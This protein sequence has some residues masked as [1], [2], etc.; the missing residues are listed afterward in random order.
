MRKTDFNIFSQLTKE[1]D[2]FNNKKIHIAGEL[3]DDSAR[4]LE[5]PTRG[6][7]FSQKEMLDLIDLYYN[8]KFETGH[9]DTEGQR[10][11]FLN[12]CAFRA[13]VASKMIDLDTKDFM[14]VPD[15]EGSKWG[16]Y[17][18]SREFKDWA[19]ENYFGELINT[20]VEKY[21]KYGTV[22]SKKVGKEIVEIPLRNLINQQDAKSLKEATHVIEV[23]RDMTI[24]EMQEFPGWDTESLAKEMSFGQTETV[25]ERY[26]K[27]PTW[28]YNKF[29][30]L[31][32]PS[33]GDKQVKY[34]VAI[35][36]LRRGNKEGDETGSILYMEET[37]CPYLEVHWKRQDGRWLG[38]GEIENQLENQISRNMIANL[39]R[40]ALLWSSK[41]IFQTTDDTVSKN[42]VR[43]VKDGDVLNITPNGQITQVDMASREIGEFNS[44]E[45]VW[46]D[47]S[48]QKSF[49]F[50]V[51]TGE[52]LPSGT[53]FRLGVVLSGAVQSHFKLKQQ[54]LGMFFKK[55]VIEDVYSIFKKQN[56]KKHMMTIFGTETGIQ[57]L[58]KALAE[59]EFNK[60]IFD[61]Y[62][63][64][65]PMPDPA[66]LKQLIED[67]YND[68]SHIYLE[69]P[70]D[71]YDTVK[72]RIELVITGEEVNVA[73]KIQTY[74]TL[75]Q[76]LAQAGDPRAEQ[77]L[78]R[79]VS[80]TG[81][82][83]EAVVGTRPT[84][85]LQQAQQPVPALTMPQTNPAQQV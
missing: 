72:H 34:V 49:T 50:E 26:G 18:I 44:A 31:T 56:S 54:K 82:T 12:I 10:K 48:N 58:K 60:Q 67:S 23:H 84:A 61:I 27:V 43:D 36:T 66:A 8:S 75:Y 63:S 19:R 5:K 71:F 21:P 81:E 32:E 41:K 78:Q 3:K 39:R 68:K 64:D 13:D 9:I 46:E 25:Y 62:M 2:D 42:L 69:I 22:V 52:S 24:D 73:S 74:S 4:Y 29:K 51:A 59:I 65:K 28:F 33:K 40:R 53:P 45:Q 17:I 38:I 14:F 37:K 85:P 16:S 79:I 7:W 47:N 76:A 70:D 80:M 11:L 83:L 55:M 30:G 6:Y 20:F 57:N 77:M 1:I 15:D 35:C